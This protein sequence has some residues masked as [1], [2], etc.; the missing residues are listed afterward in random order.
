MRTHTLRIPASFCGGIPVPSLKDLADQVRNVQI[1]RAYGDGADYPSLARCHDLTPGASA[2]S[3]TPAEP[4]AAIELPPGT[5]NEITVP[6]L[7]VH[8]TPAGGC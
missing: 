1:R 3:S 2:R 5:E 6:F 8:T 4:Q 7:K